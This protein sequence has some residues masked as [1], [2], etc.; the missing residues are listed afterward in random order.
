MT[1]LSSASERY[2]GF[3]L[4]DEEYGIPLLKVREV[5]GM[6][7]ITP[8][9]QSPKHFV[10]IMNLRGQVISIVDLRT[11]LSIPPK[12]G[13]EVAVVICDIGGAYLGVV[14]DSVN[15]V[16][17]PAP[18]QIADRPE[19]QNSK[20]NQFIT[21]VYRHDKQLV[22]LLDIARTLDMEDHAIINRTVTEPKASAA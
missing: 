14:V 18:D 22:L 15:Q 13:T 10:G 12:T 11:K 1:Q 21:G 16:Y 9:P 8:V 3:S 17:S 6:P 4:G 19:I 7:E 2:L 20:A 5:I